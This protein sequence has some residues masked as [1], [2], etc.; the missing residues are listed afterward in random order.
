MPENTIAVSHASLQELEHRIHQITLI[1]DKLDL[2]AFEMRQ[3]GGFLK[4]ASKK[5]RPTEGN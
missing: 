2:L 3:A 1:I 4:D 5:I